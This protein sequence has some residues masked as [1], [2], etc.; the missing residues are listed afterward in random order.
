MT[1]KNWWKAGGEAG[2][3]VEIGDEDAIAR[4]GFC[5][6]ESKLRLSP[7]K[8]DA[9]KEL[10]GH[11]K[12]GQAANSR[13]KQ[14]ESGGKRFAGL[15]LALAVD[16]RRDD[17]GVRHSFGF[18]QRRRGIFRHRR[19]EELVERTRRAQHAGV[20]RNRPH[21]A[22]DFAKRM[23]EAAA[24]SR[25]GVSG[26]AERGQGL[27]VEAEVGKLQVCEFASC[28]LEVRSCGVHGVSFFRKSK[29]KG[30]KEKGKQITGTS[31][32]TKSFSKFFLAVRGSI[33][34]FLFSFCCLLFALQNYPF[35]AR[36]ASG[37]CVTI[38]ATSHLPLL[39]FSIPAR[40]RIR[41]DS[42]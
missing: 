4:H 26:K 21:G 20:A 10:E 30:Q 36:Q 40:R 35:E 42:K 39:T 5:R 34:P 14:R 11:E 19:F 24:Q 8:P 12:I 38:L 1:I 28:K 27:E 2:F 3:A 15:Q 13:A 29:S 6:R 32:R 23:A 16:F 31:N 17:E 25:A 22:D 33:I 41:L 7:T 18:L 37:K 9:A